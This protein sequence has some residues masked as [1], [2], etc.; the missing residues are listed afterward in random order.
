MRAFDVP[1]AIPDEEP[2]RSQKIAEYGEFAC[3]MVSLWSLVK[4]QDPIEGRLDYS[5]EKFRLARECGHD[6]FD[7][8]LEDWEVM[9]ALQTV[10]DTKSSDPT[11][12][13][14]LGGSE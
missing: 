5:A 13:R 9:S 7:L 2:A 14:E 12:W 1:H 10:V 6:A 8:G 4:T 11:K 3:V